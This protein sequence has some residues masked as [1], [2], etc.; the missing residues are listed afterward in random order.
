MSFLRTIVLSALL[1]FSFSAHAVMSASDWENVG[2]FIGNK[3][4][5]NMSYTKSD[6]GTIH[7]P[8]SHPSSARAKEA[9]EL[10]DFSEQV[11]RSYGAPKGWKR[12]KNISYRSGF[13]A[14]IFQRGSNI[15]LAYRGSELGSSDWVTD[16]ILSN[17]KVPTQFLQAIHL[18]LTV[19]QH[20]P[21]HRIR[22]TGH[23]LGGG[24][25]TAAAL[26][27]G[28]PTVAFDATGINE[29]IKSHIIR[30]LGNS[31]VLSLHAQSIVNYNF[32]GEFVSDGDGQQDADVLGI[33]AKQYGDI[34]YLSDR[35]FNPFPNFIWDN[36]LTRHFIS[37]IRE[38]LH[39]ILNPYFFDWTPDEWDIIWFKMN[40][41]V[42]SAPSLFQDIGL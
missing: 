24:L 6:T 14:S 26:M 16:G 19:E 2:H 18:A 31:F 35:H 25:S 40:Y 8:S 39:Y 7:P 3:V 5:P 4:R 10:L 23:S 33:N 9:L 32:E 11:Y 28:R 29:A 42:N 12:I 41:V 38:E 17:G 22:Y 1:S 27:T 30:L 15:I 36:H 20:Y 34:Y 13:N 37:P 21:N